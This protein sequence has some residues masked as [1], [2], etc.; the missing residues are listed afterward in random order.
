MASGVPPRAAAG[1]TWSDAET[2]PLLL[3]AGAGFGAGY[4]QVITRSIAGVPAAQAHDASGLFNTI[5]MLGFA[6]GVATL[7][8]AFLSAVGAPTAAETGSAFEIVAIGCGALSV[9]GA[10]FVLALARAEDRA[11]AAQSSGLNASSA[12]VLETA[13]MIAATTSSASG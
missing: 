3:L 2:L 1:G 11:A 6:L 10:G 8:S 13:P 9:A 4:S 12:S 5:N 7:G